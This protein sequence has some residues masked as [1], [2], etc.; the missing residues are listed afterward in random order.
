MS[1]MVCCSVTAVEAEYQQGYEEAMDQMKGTKSLEELLKGNHGKVISTPQDYMQLKLN[2]GSYCAL[3]WSIFGKQC[4]YYR[5]LLKLYR[6]LDREECF[7]IQDAYTREICARITWAIINDGCSF[8][9]RNPVVSNFMPGARVNFSCHFW[10]QSPT[11]CAM[12]SQSNAQLSQGN[13]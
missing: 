1:M 5:K 7:T 3:L 13:G 10:N 8:F 2:I 4:D 12:P 9:G 11:R 6:I